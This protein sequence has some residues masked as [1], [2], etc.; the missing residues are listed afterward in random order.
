MRV[1]VMYNPIS[2]RG[3]SSLLA[4]AIAAL[5][6]S[7]PCDVELVQTHP[8]SPESWLTPK[9][10]FKPDAVIAVGGDGTLRQVAS[11][12]VGT[13]IPL[14]H[15]ACGTENLFAKSMGMSS[16]PKVVIAA[17]E[18]AKAQTI[19]TATANGEFLVLMASVG[20]DAGVVADLAKHRGTSITHLS[21]I[22]PIIRQLFKWNLPVITIEVDGEEIVSNTK[23]WAV[24]ANSNAYAR[25]LNPA[26]DADNTDG[27]LDVVFFP[28][29][30]RFQLWKWI[31]LMKRGTQLQQP[32]VVYVKGESVSVRTTTPSPWQIDGDSIG[33]ASNMNI[34]CVP[35]SLSVL[36]N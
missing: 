5:L 33:N 19:D 22:A 10:Q 2:G 35:K 20:F 29:K 9:L 7:I 30:S 6:Q 15:A 32:E 16:T 23:G 36:V 18:N 26:I 13:S 34:T 17:T 11:G 14:Y 1:L 3:K 25:G 12:L 4:Q 28:L 31:R 8:S 27:K 21:Y 24:I